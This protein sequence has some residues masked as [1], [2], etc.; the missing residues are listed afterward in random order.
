MYDSAVRDNLTLGGPSATG[1]VRVTNVANGEVSDTSKDAVNGSQLH[2]TN[3][4][5]ARNTSDI[6]SLNTSITS[7]NIGLTQQDAVSRNLTVGKSTDGTAVD[8]SGTAGA[9]QL[10]GVANGTVSRAASSPST[11]INCTARAARLLVRLAVA[12]L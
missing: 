2:A 9:R 12:R 1:A 4:R 3:T 10:H 8:F 7:G 6:A 11:A 5:V